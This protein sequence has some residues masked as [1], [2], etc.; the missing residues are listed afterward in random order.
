MVVH[1]QESL[2]PTF[3]S[4]GVGLSSRPSVL[5]KLIAYLVFRAMKQ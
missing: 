3:I 1:A 2:E 4:I 5:P